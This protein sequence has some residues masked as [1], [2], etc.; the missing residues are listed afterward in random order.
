MP[1]N[2]LTDFSLCLMIE[3]YTL[4][5]V[6]STTIRHSAIG[7]PEEMLKIKRNDTAPILRAELRNADCQPVFLTSKNPI[8][9][10][11]REH[12]Y[13]SEDKECEDLKVLETPNVILSPQDSHRGRFQYVWQEGDTDKAGPYIAE[14]EVLLN[15]V[16]A[17][18]TGPFELED[19]MTLILTAEDG[20]SQT[21]T[22]LTADF[23]DIA[24]ATSQEIVTKINA[25]TTG[26]TATATMDGTSFLIQ[27]DTTTTSGSIQVSGG[28]ANAI[29]GF[30]EEIFPNRK[31]SLPNPGL[32]VMIYEDHNEE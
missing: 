3:E 12:F 5:F 22:F 4:R 21:V 14:F 30:D 17:G 8:K 7:E 9:F 31:I 16:E 32:S 25:S 20:T 2:D 27:T 13:Y 19:G 24:Q 6:D 28:T 10:I 23:A 29:F 18:F 26:I 1:L 15:G 11:M